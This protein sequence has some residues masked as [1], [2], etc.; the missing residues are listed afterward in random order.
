VAVRIRAVS[1]RVRGMVRFSVLVWASTPMSGR[2]SLAPGRGL[3]TPPPGPLTVDRITTSGP[4]GDD[5]R[6]VRRLLRRR[7][8]QA[9][10]ALV[11]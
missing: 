3:G 10:G 6:L 9:A 7:R 11:H 5:A 8:R 2:P 1:E 4:G